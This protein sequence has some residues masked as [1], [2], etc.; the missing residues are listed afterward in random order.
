MIGGG[1]YGMPCRTVKLFDGFSI[2]SVRAMQTKEPVFR[3]LSRVLLLFGVVI[4]S[5]ACDEDLHVASTIVLTPQP[6]R[7]TFSGP[8]ITAG[9]LRRLCFQ[10]APEDARSVLLAATRISAVLIDSA[11]NRDSMPIS[12]RGDLFQDDDRVCMQ[13]QGLAREFPAVVCYT[14]PDWPRRRCTVSE[15]SIRKLAELPCTRSAVY[16]GVELTASASLPVKEVT[17]YSGAPPSTWPKKTTR[18]GCFLL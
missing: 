18:E 9:P 4:G 8:Y 12:S 5:A 13:D 16:G 1:R 14:Q 17:F 7:L 11:G 2:T 10:L 3:S 6:S 15:D